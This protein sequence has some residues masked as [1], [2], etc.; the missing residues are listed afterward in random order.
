V[1]CDFFVQHSCQMSQWMRVTASQLICD[2]ASAENIS[3]SHTSRA[4]MAPQDTL[5]SQI[6]VVRVSFHPF[7]FVGWPTKRKTK[8]DFFLFLWWL[9]T[10]LVVHT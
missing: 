9:C 2:L 5:Q 4:K 10:Q 3:K 7:F 8:T 1:R 6:T